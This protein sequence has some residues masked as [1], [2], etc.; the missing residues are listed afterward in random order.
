MTICPYTPGFKVCLTV[1]HRKF[2]ELTE[3]KAQKFRPLMGF[4]G[5]RQISVA[6]SKISDFWISCGTRPS[7]L[8]LFKMELSIVSDPSSQGLDHVSEQQY[9]HLQGN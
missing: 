2:F 1:G 7:S 5:S 9:S 8:G 3:Q 4:D 6:Q